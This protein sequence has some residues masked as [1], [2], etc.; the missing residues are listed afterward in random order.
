MSYSCYNISSAASQRR[1]NRIGNTAT[2]QR[3][4]THTPVVRFVVLNIIAPL[5]CKLRCETQLCD[6]LPCDTST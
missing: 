6:M 1:A 2:Q 4:H 5:H 3:T